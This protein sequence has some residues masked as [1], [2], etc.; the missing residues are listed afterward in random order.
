MKEPGPNNL[1]GHRSGR[2]DAA[3][4]HSR[5]GLMRGGLWAIA[6]VL[7]AALSLWLYINLFSLEYGVW[8]V[9]DETLDGILA[10][11]SLLIPVVLTLWVR[12][13]LR[14]PCA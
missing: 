6:A 5:P 7:G 2:V 10:V 1:A 4:P 14:G 11:V 9:G 8:G 3:P 13:L 12:R